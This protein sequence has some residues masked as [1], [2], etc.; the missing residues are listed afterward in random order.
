MRSMRVCLFVLTVVGAQTIGCGDTGQPTLT[1]PLYAAG[2]EAKAVLLG[3]WSVKLDVA[4]LAFGPARFCAS[5]SAAETLCPAALAEYADSAGGIDLL[6]T[7]PAR[8][9]VVQGFVGTVRSVSFGYGYTW[10]PTQAEARPTSHSLDGH[11]AHLEGTATSS[12]TPPAVIKFVADVDVVPST[13]GS[14]PVGSTISDAAIDTG[15][16]RL[17]VTIDAGA[18]LQQVDFDELARATESPVRIAA[19]SR[20]HNAIVVGMTTL[21]TPRF[22]WSRTP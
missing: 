4:R 17:D 12:S 1:H 9:G 14:Y 15:T 3:S 13:R 7:K 22:T 20:A 19:G 2:T 11:S 18:W 10:L 16:A 8:I 21:A 5:R 6:S